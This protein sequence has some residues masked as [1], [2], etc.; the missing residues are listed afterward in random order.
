MTASDHL[1]TP[2]F[3]EHDQGRIDNAYNYARRQGSSYDEADQYATH[4]HE[5]RT[6]GVLSPGPHSEHYS[7]WYNHVKRR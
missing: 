3:S 7:H 4:I 5:G 2:Q 1:S 6:S